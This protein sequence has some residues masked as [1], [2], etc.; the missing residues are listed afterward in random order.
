VVLGKVAQGEDPQGARAELLARPKIT[1][2]ALCAQYFAEKRTSPSMAS[3]TIKGYAS[4]A[5]NHLGA[6][7]HLQADELDAQAV[8]VRVREIAKQSEYTADTFRAMLASVYKWAMTVYPSIIVASPVSGTWRPERQPTTGRA[9]TIEQLG[10]IWRACEM[11]DGMAMPMCRNGHIMSR[12]HKVEGA[13]GDLIAI[14]RFAHLTGFNHKT[15][16]KAV[17]DG[18]LQ[19]ATPSPQQISKAQPR[20]HGPAPHFTTVG[21]LNRYID[22]RAVRSQRGDYSKVVRLAMLFGARYGEMAGLRWSEI[23][24]PLGD[25]DPLPL[26]TDPTLRP[27]ERESLRAISQR[28]LHIK[29]IPDGAPVGHRR[30]KSRGG[31][32]KDLIL[33]LPDA[34][35]EILKSIPRQANR[36]LVFGSGQYGAR[37]NGHLTRDLNSII[38]D[39]EGEAF[40][41]KH[42]WMRHAFST[43]L[44]EILGPQASSLVELMVNH[45]L[46]GEAATYTH[47]RFLEQQKPVLEMW[48]QRIRDAADRV[49]TSRSN[50]RNLFAPPA[51]TA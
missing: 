38:K 26:D 47:T 11:L 29:T 18:K 34:A 20:R 31:K 12:P 24:R 48:A 44:K 6:L 43:R 13:E 35:I 42:H 10:A 49:D 8:V 9:L 16:R 7:R 41:W 33:Y 5:K 46:K 32:P 39:N 27:S 22:T 50:V 45:V 30:I 1:V 4:V 37:A 21:E 17:T 40:K 15:L 25:A 14:R 3:S 28:V 36:D 19:L 51:E 2:G 23:T